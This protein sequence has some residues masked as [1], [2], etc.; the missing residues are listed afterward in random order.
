MADQNNPPRTWKDG[1]VAGAMVIFAA[2][3]SGVASY[4]ATWNIEAQKVELEN[5]KDLEDSFQQELSNVLVGMR[6]FMVKYSKSKNV[7]EEAR[8]EIMEAVLNM[9][10]LF[11]PKT[12]R[13]PEKYSKD[14]NDIINIL[15]DFR[16]D[17][18][19]AKSPSEVDAA[20]NLMYVLFRK[21]D[22][23]FEKMRSDTE[24]S[25]MKFVPVSSD[26]RG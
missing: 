18:E 23:L 6:K 1:A 9:H 12:G 2:L 8:E 17:L 10:I 7:D 16:K 21:K 14:A 26:K 5:A 11:H 22:A 24:L 15:V 20:S 13:W 25:I 4:V 3:A 19:A